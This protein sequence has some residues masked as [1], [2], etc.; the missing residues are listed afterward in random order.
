EC[1]APAKPGEVKLR[2][3]VDDPNKA[4]AAPN[5]D[6][7]PLNNKIETYITVTKEGVSVL[8]VDKQR[9]MEPQFICDAL[10]LDP[11]IRV[12]P[13]W[14]RGGQTLDANSGDLFHFDKQPYD[15][16]I[17][18]DVTAAQMQAV[19]LQ[20]LQAIERLVDQGSGLLMLGGYSTFGNSDW[21]G[22]LM[23]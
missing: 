15:V 11:R 22:T 4:D 10:T 13:V 17:L 1:N 19:N 14:L 20:S 21:Q 12:T 3:R 7:F 8:L 5:G 23:A 18:G 16:V 2:V 9:A 6:L